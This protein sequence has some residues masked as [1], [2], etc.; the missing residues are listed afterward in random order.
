MHRAAAWLALVLVLACRESR[1]GV[2]ETGTPDV[3][4]RTGSPELEDN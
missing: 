1:S 3:A 4:Q 2:P